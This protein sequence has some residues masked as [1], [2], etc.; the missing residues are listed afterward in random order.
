[1]SSKGIALITVIFVIMVLMILGLNLSHSMRFGLLAIRNLKEEERI[2]YAMISAIN[3]AISYIAQ[4]NS[5][6][7]DYMDEKGGIHLDDR[8]PFPQGFRYNGA[9][10]KLTITD[11]ESRLNVNFLNDLRLRNLLKYADVPD[12]KIQIIIDSLRDWTDPDDLHRPSGAEK[13]YYESLDEPYIP[14]NGPLNVPEELLLI[15]EFKKDYFHGSEDR[16][17]I[18]DLITTFGSGRININTVS[19]EVMEVLGLGSSEIETIVLQRNA[20]R[21]YK[22]IPPHLT[23]LFSTTY[24]NTFRIEVQSPALLKK[25]TAIVQRVHAKK[26][27]TTKILYW[28]EETIG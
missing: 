15:R 21:G 2:H 1:M 17:G 27:F 23:G 25:I 26:G 4:D 16:K 3:K 19:K 11:E 20:L 18:K 14:K 24:S 7:V 28:K 5:P 6:L 13:E 8:E 22:A 12:D 10:L 9:E